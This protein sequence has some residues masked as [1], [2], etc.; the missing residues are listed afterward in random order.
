MLNKDTDVV[1]VTERVTQFAHLDSNSTLP[2]TPELIWDF[3]VLKGSAEDVMIHWSFLIA[4]LY[5]FIVLLV[6]V[7]VYVLYPENTI[8]PSR[9]AI[10]Q[11]DELKAKKDAFKLNKP[12]SNCLKIFVVIVSTVTMHVYCGLEISFGALLSPFAVK[13]N[14]HMT[15]SEGSFLTS[16][17]W[18]TFTFLRAFSLIGIIYLSPR[19]LLLINFAI[20]MISNGILLP[21][22][23]AHRW[24]RWKGFPAHSV[25]I[26]IRT[27]YK[28]LVTNGN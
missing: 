20:I 13:S 22:G 5:Y 1:V 15:K 9:T 19:L 24:G 16:A 18:G 28:L 6:F 14:L 17:Y 11:D 7:L 26:I 21:L 8:H 2:T 27:T 23:N 25:L 3:N 10:D 4:A 12:L